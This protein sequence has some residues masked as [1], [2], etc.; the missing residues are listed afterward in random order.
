MAVQALR[1]G[2][3]RT[4]TACGTNLTLG[5]ES[6]IVD[7][8]LGMLSP[9]GLG[10]MWDQE[11]NGY[12][13]GEG[14]AAILLKKLSAALEDGDHIELI[15]STYARAGLDL[16]TPD[17]QPQYF[18]AHGTGTP[19]GDPME[20]E[21][22]HRV[23]S[24][25]RAP[26]DVPLYNSCAP[27]NMLFDRLSDKVAPF[28]H[29]VKILKETKPGPEAYTVMR[30]S[31][32]SFGFGGANA[33]AV[34]K[35]Y[36]EKPLSYGAPKLA[37]AE[38]PISFAFS[39]AS[40]DPLRTVLSSYLDFLGGEG[41]SIDPHHL[42]WVLLQRRSVLPWRVSFAASSVASLRDK[43]RAALEKET[44]V[45]GVEALPESGTH[46]L[47]I[48]T[49]QGAYVCEVFD[50]DFVMQGCIRYVHEVGDILIPLVGMESSKYLLTT[51][52]V[53]KVK[54]NVSENG[55][56]NGTVKKPMKKH[57]DILPMEVWMRKATAAGMH[58]AVA[59]LIQAMDAP[60]AAYPKLLKKM[61]DT[62]CIER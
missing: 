8:K 40:R 57:F 26:N 22:I 32:N 24:A 1:S 21:A 61:A 58:P 25:T 47:G 29:N 60:G 2:E 17:D 36:D 28:Y 13:R 5:P 53:D 44:S 48:F 33:H 39:A 45:V 34:L 10:R 23:F 56:L 62:P 18:E 46:L 6:F 35:S 19:A 15:R 38:L 43:I 20:A 7:S 59:E 16:A 52:G 30:V 50:D 9:D 27:P 51:N 37:K 14:V 11:V 4:A 3:A 31:V 42:A 55:R 12:A 41:A 49:G 54:E